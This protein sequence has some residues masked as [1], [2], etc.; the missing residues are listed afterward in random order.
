MNKTEEWFICKG[1][2][3]FIPVHTIKIHREQKCS[4]W[5]WVYNNYA[6]QAQWFISHYSC[7]R[8]VFLK[9]F[10]VEEPLRYLFISRETPAHWG[11]GGGDYEEMVIST[12]RLLQYFK[13]PDKNS[14]SILRCIYN[15]FAVFQTSYVF[16]PLF[17]LESLTIIIIVLIVREDL[18][19]I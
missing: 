9:L 14:C 7:L 5:S 4:S 16:I 11:G 12:W 13:L 3:W 8:P 2:C 19:T 1:R 18:I 17:L 10:P 6:I 15:F